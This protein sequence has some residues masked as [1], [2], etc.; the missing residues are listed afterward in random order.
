MADGKVCLKAERFV[1]FGYCCG[2]VEGDESMVLMGDLGSRI[3]TV[4]TMDWRRE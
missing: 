1:N 4:L 3:L 2:E